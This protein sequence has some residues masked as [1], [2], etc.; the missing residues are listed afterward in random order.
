MSYLLI[1]LAAFLG[2]G[3]LSAR[4][5]RYYQRPDDDRREV[6]LDDLDVGGGD[7]CCDR[8]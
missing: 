5:R 4:P 3:L 2:L 8:D 7:G 6:I 1:F